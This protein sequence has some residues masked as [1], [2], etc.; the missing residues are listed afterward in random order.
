MN[1]KE[2][3]AVAIAGVELL[4]CFVASDCVLHARNIIKDES[5]PPRNCM[6]NSLNRKTSLLKKKS[7]P[8]E[9]PITKAFPFIS[10]Q[11]HSPYYGKPMLI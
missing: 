9:K 4:A 2:K 8:K 10:R 7:L 6:A 3:V 1:T 5:M 11:I